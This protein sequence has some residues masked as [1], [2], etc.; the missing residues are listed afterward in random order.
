M[1]NKKK[2]KIAVEIAAIIFA[3][4]VTLYFTQI[5]TYLTLRN[6]DT[7]E[8]YK[9]FSLSEGDGFSIGFIHSVNKSPVIDF[10]EIR[11]GNIYVVKT[12]YYHFG[13]G[14]QTDIEPGQTLTYGEDGSMIV[15]GIDVMIPHLS[16]M[17][18]TWS[19]H[20]LTINDKKVS[21][22]DLCGRSSRVH[23]SFEKGLF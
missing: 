1:Q 18:G 23:V 19:D 15:S 20:T 9:R 4:V 2:Y 7:G 13:A 16:Y 10:Y 6:N 3:A 12:V 8:I 17:V 11:D 14:V 5:K 22:R 21:L